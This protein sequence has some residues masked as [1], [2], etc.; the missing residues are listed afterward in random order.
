MLI[1]YED[2]K[3]LKLNWIE[4][5]IANLKVESSNLSKHEMLSFHSRLINSPKQLTITGWGGARAPPKHPSSK[6]TVLI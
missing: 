4:R 1:E 5:Q 3:C 6:F 2:L